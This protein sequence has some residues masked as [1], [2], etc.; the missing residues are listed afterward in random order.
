MAED[1]QDRTREAEAER[2][3]EIESEMERVGQDPDQVDDGSENLGG[4]SAPSGEARS[5]RGERE[6]D[7][8][9]TAS[10][11]TQE[12]PDDQQES[13]WA[14]SGGDEELAEEA[15]ESEAEAEE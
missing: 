9:E 7:E 5:N 6:D 14:E 11:E 13:Q 12:L 15:L 3:A 4:Q 8:A 2:E 1:D 10:E